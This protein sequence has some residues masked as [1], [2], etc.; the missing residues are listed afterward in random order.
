[1][2][3]RRAMLGIALA[4]C[5]LGPRA[6]AE[7]GARALMRRVFDQVKVSFIAKMKLSSED[8]LEQVLDVRHKQFAQASATYMEV[9]EPFNMKDTRFLSWDRDGSSDEHYTYVPMVKRSLQVADWTLKQSFLGSTFYMVDIAVPDMEE[10]EYSFNGKMQVGDTPCIGVEGI[11]KEIE[12]EP[13]S[14]IVYCIDEGKLLSIHTEFFDPEGVLLKVWR[15]EK[16]EEIGGIWTPTLQTM[17]DVQ[18]ETESRLEILEIQMHVETPD[19][20]FRKAYLDR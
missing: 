10:Y 4:A 5:L 8:G 19:K 15:P 11:P 13:Y 20:V 14:R 18:A 12:D 2:T 7:D 1:M 17:T 9:R 3:R 16:V 6:A